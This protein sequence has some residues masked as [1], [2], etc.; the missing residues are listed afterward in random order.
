MVKS[1]V[2][3]NLVGGS[4]ILQR[5]RT[6]GVCLWFEGR[7][8]MCGRGEFW[9]W[10][11][12]PCVEPGALEMHELLRVSGATEGKIID[13]DRPQRK[14]AAATRISLQHDPRALKDLPITSEERVYALGKTD[15]LCTC[16]RELHPTSYISK[17][18]TSMP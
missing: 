11:M 7:E 1:P 5:S 18:K 14:G 3:Q 9:C 16:R 17:S 15:D 13:P 6:R 2:K 4:R 12:V 10:F 8:K